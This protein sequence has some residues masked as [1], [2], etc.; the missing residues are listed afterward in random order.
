MSSLSIL[1]LTPLP[2][3]AQVDAQ[4]MLRLFED[5]Y[6]HCVSWIQQGCPSRRSE[7]QAVW[8]EPGSGSPKTLVMEGWKTLRELVA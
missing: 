2:V 3:A 7:R 5:G 6:R 1:I 4:D 8:A